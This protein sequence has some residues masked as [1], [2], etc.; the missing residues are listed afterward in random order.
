ME[1]S[2]KS[3]YASFRQRILW[4]DRQPYD[5]LPQLSQKLHF[6]TTFEASVKRLGTCIKTFFS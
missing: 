1:K 6:F 3:P 2:D 5:V 4:Y